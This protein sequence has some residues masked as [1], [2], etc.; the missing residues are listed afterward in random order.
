MR[1]L[2]KGDRQQRTVVYWLGVARRTR[3][4]RLVN[5]NFVGVGREVGGGLKIRLRFPV[6]PCASPLVHNFSL[7]A[8]SSQLHVLVPSPG[9]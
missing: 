1:L 5:V 2:R 3:N 8:Y 6:A 9:F 4:M 7:N